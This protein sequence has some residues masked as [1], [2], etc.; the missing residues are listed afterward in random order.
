MIKNNLETSIILGI[1]EAAVMLIKQNIEF[2][3]K[4]G[5]TNKQWVV[6]I[7]LAKDPNLPILIREEHQKPMMAYEL[8]DSLGVTRANV[9][10]LI[11]SLLNKKLINQIE[12]GEDR[13][14][15]RLVLT[16][17]GEALIKK[18]Q[19]SRMKTNAEMLDGF[20]EKEKKDFLVYIQ[21]CAKNIQAYNKD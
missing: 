17:K 16:K 14:K 19:P 6:L 1:Y 2:V 10:N 20:T 21:K 5:L 9:T 13:R 4:Q 12:D 3:A 11:K 15:K 18:M 8:A 7:H